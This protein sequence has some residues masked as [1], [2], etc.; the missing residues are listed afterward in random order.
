MKTTV[1]Q[2]AAGTFIALLLMVGN[3]K[4]TE[5]KTSSCA[6]LETTLQLENWMTDDIVWNTNSITISELAVET[7]TDL[8]LENWMTDA[9]A[10][11]VNNSFVE[12]AESAMELEDWMINDANWNADNTDIEADLTVENWMVDNNLWE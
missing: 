12:V 3:V 4:A 2:I 6:M 11:N 5:T 8:L 9:E 10:W 1:K 7:E